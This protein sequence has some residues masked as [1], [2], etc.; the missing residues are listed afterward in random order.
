MPTQEVRLQTKTGMPIME[1]EMME[2]HPKMGA[3]N[4]E[5]M[6]ETILKV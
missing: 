3:I 6:E 5:S 2:P 1:Q 4:M